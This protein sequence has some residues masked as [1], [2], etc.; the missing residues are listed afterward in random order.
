MSFLNT[1]TKKD[2]S[3]GLPA[4]NF[5][6]ATVQRNFWAQS[7]LALTFVNKQS[8]G[9]LDGDSLT[10]FHESIWKNTLENNRRYL[11]KNTF[12]RVLDLDL[13][14]LSKD[15]KWHSS[16]FAAQSYDDFSKNR[17]LSAGIFFEYST[18]HVYIRSRPSYIGKNFNAEAGFVPSYNVYPGQINFI[19]S[20]TYIF[21]PNHRNLITMGPIVEISQTY[22]PDGPLTDKDYS[23]GYS[24]NFTSSATLEFRYN[25]IFQQLTGDFNPIDENR[26]REFKEG[27]TYDWHTISAMLKTNARKL[28]NAEIGFTYGGFYNGTNLNISG[29]FNVRYQPY[30]NVSLNFD[31]NDLRLP[32]HYGKE[33]L[34]LIGPRIDLTFTDKLFLTTYYQYNNLLDNMNLNLRFQWRYKPASD[35][36]LVY[37]ENYFPKGFTSR[38]RAIVFKLNHWLNI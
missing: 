35:L 1:Q 23:F 30:G 37:T 4:Q 10:Y 18:R 2:L 21:Y 13:E 29:K 33:K 27:E 6:V 20:L 5:S 28:V 9:V 15:N 14:L 24:F 38:N 31:Y 36:F 19:N 34:F 8:W 11:K 32:G 26:Y 12:N 25:Y 7:S 22:I 3:L 16:F 17:N